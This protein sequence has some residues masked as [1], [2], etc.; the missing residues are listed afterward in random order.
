LHKSKKGARDEAKQQTRAMSKLY[1][2]HFEIQ[3]YRIRLVV[4]DAQYVAMLVLL[5]SSTR[6]T[7]NQEQ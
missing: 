3:G 1:G 5:T 2:N 7:G 6:A 4:R